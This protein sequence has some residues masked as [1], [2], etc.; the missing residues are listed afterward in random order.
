MCKTSMLHRKRAVHM[1]MMRNLKHQENHWMGNRKDQRT[2]AKNLEIVQLI[3][4]EIN[5]ILSS[6]ST[7]RRRHQG[8]RIILKLQINRRYLRTVKRINNGMFTIM[9]VQANIS[10]VIQLRPKLRLLIT[11]LIQIMPKFYIIK[12]KLL[13]NMEQIQSLILWPSKLRVSIQIFHK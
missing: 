6:K 10:K 7:V 13:I 11:L 2:G 3:A 12:V 4:S 1:K 8:L 9:T 5:K